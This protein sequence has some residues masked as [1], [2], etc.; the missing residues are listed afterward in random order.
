[1]RRSLPVVAG[2][3]PM[4]MTVTPLSVRSDYKLSAHGHRI[5]GYVKGEQVIDSGWHTTVSKAC[6]AYGRELGRLATVHARRYLP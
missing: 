6:A 2:V 1:M 4:T 3:D 5:L